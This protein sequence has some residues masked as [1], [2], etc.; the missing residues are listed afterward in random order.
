M[1]K[2]RLTYF[3]PTYNREK[4]LPKLYDSLLN[5]TNKNFV[6]LVIDDGSTDGTETLVQGWQKENKI[7]IE[8]IKKE[9]GGK[10]TAI[11]LSNQVCT[12]E[13]ITCIDSDDYITQN[14]TD[15]LYACFSHISED[16]TVVGIV[17]RRD[18]VG[19]SKHKETDWPKD[20]ELLYFNELASKFG[21][22]YD[23]ILVFKTNIIKNYTF[24]TFSDER[25]VTESVFYNKFMFDYKMMAIEDFIYIGEYQEDGYTSMGMKLFI[26]NP[27][28]YACHLKQEAFLAIKKHKKSLIKRIKTVM[29]Y[30]GW[31]SLFKIKQDVMPEYKFGWFYTFVGKT[32]SCFSKFIIK[33]RLK[34]EK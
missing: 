31:K 28:G 27:K 12:T 26:K 21:F 4:L 33:R 25:F 32:T 6:W 10:H 1:E 7:K 29:R 19:F 18:L 3:T 16:D 23:T 11:D 15:V 9:N 13:F 5:Q 22:C 14:C 8:Y 30:Y 17:G 24:P 20:K 2:I 34:N